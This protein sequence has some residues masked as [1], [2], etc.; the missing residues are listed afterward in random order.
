MPVLLL[1]LAPDG[2]VGVALAGLLTA[3]T[4]GMAADVSSFD[5]VVTDDLWQDRIRPGRDDR[6]HLRVNRPV[7]VVGTALAI[8][9]AFT[10]AGSTNT[11]DDIQTLFSVFDVQLFAVFALG[12][13]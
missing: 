6:H 5:T 13:F 3:F 8:G 2:L 10:A 11:V 4:A 1:G 7:T 12:L 9:A